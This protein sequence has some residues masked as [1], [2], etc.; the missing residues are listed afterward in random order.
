MARRSVVGLAFPHLKPTATTWSE[1]GKG[2]HVRLEGRRAVAAA[3]LLRDAWLGEAARAVSLAMIEGGN[4]WNPYPRRRIYAVTEGNGAVSA[5]SLRRTRNMA[6]GNGARGAGYLRRNCALVEGKRAGDTGSLRRYCTVGICDRRRRSLW[7]RNRGNLCCIIFIG[8]AGNRYTSILRNKRRGPRQCCW[9]KG[10]VCRTAVELSFAG[11][12]GT[13]LARV[14]V[15]L[16][17][18]AAPRR[19]PGAAA[20][21]EEAGEGGTPPWWPDVYGLPGLPL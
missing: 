5:G 12:E 21:A 10:R 6:E 1:R 19:I 7:G 11:A 17:L 2:E 15:P 20:G 13:W 3:S 16:G 9:R 8:Q 14:R 4:V 18:W